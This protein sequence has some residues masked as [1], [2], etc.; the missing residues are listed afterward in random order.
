MRSNISTFYKCSLNTYNNDKN[1]DSIMNSEDTQTLI[2]QKRKLLL[3]SKIKKLQI[4]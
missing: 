1:Y 2:D 3:K 4:L